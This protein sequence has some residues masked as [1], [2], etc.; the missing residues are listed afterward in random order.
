[1][2]ETSNPKVVHYKVNGEEQTTTERTLTV[3][4]ILRSAGA[5]ASIDVKQL[6]SYF[7]E[8]IAGGAKYENITDV[9]P[10][11]DGDQ[12]I[13]IHVGKTPVA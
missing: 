12:F 3:E 8:N 7:L 11:T 6:D 1:M 4:A 9:V 10:V 13:A 5:A 2:S